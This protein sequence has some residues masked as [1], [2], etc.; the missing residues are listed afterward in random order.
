MDLKFVIGPCTFDSTLCQNEGQCIDEPNV[1][2]GFQCLCSH[3][4]HGEFCEKSDRLT[5]ET[6]HQNT[7]ELSSQDQWTYV[8]LSVSIER[9]MMKIFSLLI[10]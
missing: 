6:T 8:S 7:I 10:H 3:P 2:K 1:S 4:F 9:E 5:E